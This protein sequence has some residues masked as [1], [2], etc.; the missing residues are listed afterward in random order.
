MEIPAVESPTTLTSHS[1]APYFVRTLRYAALIS[2][3]MTVASGV[4]LPFLQPV[5]PLFY[6][7][8]QPDKQLAPKI[9]IILLPI[10][11]W[12]ITIGHFIILRNMKSLEGSMEKIFCWATFGLVAITGLLFIRIISL[13]I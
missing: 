10:M 13:T 2:L 8:S 9:W 3:L 12:L 4:I 5:I 7:L 11:A 1:K 6:S